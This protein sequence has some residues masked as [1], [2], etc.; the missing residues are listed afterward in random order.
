[1]L[2]GCLLAG[3]FGILRGI[4]NGFVALAA[5]M[6]LIGMVTPLVPLNTLKVCGQWF[7]R[8]QW[9]LA[10]GVLSMGMALGFL[11]GS[12]FSATVLSPWL[13]GWRNVL[14]FYSGIAL[15]LS[16]PWAFTRPWASS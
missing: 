8:R 5:G 9:G 15:L 1:L 16:I 7:S 13:G 6:F 2:V 11:L 4:S 3:L 10:S 12:L 14:Y